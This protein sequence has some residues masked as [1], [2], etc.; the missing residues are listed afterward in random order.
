MYVQFNVSQSLA[1]DILH[2]AE[3]RVFLH[4]T[5]QSDT[6]QRHR[7]SV[8]QLLTQSTDDHHEPPSRL[9]D[10]KVVHRGR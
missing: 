6:A 1:D 10:T 4:D 3:L 7:V 2:G 8:Y 5:E 9:V